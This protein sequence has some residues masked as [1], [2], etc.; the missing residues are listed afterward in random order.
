MG[1]IPS[2]YGFRL[3]CGST[4]ALALIGLLYPA[5]GL[6]AQPSA[7]NT[8]MVPWA[9]APKGVLS[10]SAMSLKEALAY[11]RFHQPELRAAR[12]R[13]LAVSAD[14]RVPSAQWLPSA[15]AALEVVGSSTNNSTSTIYR[16]D[17]VDL[18]RIGGTTIHSTPD[19]QPYATTL[20]TVGLRQEIFDFGRIAAQ[21]A[22]GDA[23]VAIER[24]RLQAT[25]IDI[26]LIVTQAYYAVKAARA[27]MDAA[28]QAEQ[29]AQIHSAFAEAGVKAGMRPPIEITRAKA[30]LTRFTV[31]RIRSEGNLRVAR[32]VLA[33]AVGFTEAELDSTQSQE[34]V[35]ATPPLAQVEQRAKAFQPEILQAVDR[36]KA[37]HAQTLAIS[38]STRP[39]L[40]ATAALSAR[41]GGA[42]S[43]NGFVP[44]GRG[45]IPSVPNYDA[46]LIMSWPFYEPTVDAAA[47]A[48]RQR[49]WVYDA[50]VAAAQ[51]RAVA[52]AQQ[53]YRRT[54]VAESALG[55]LAQ[56]AEAAR[57]N[58]E[59]ADAR[60]KAGLGTSTEL[61]DAEAIRFEAEV[62][63]AVGGFE[64]A[65]A[66]ANLARVMGD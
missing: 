17:A 43:N 57:A 32:S 27:V 5:A 14:A 65:T 4:L 31:G 54:R 12:E 8:T 38:A 11:A 50:E 66:R 33:A 36:R 62:Q 1:T 18:P 37:Q 64:L 3:R 35:P 24:D 20:A 7:P 19:W 41:A 6:R 42:P 40:F 60:F 34:P 16:N 49:E 48:S 47:S 44:E 45:L 22:A 25:H 13:F 21:T 58:Y 52:A 15:G 46:G 2:N 53:A 30:D 56:A 59:Q 55:A 39:N 28:T 23:L 63:Q 51:Q 29:R 10:V 9:P 26:T 61:A